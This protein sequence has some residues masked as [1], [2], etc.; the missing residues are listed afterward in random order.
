MICIFD[1]ML[2]E[3]EMF[4]VMVLRVVNVSQI[5]VVVVVCL[6]VFVECDG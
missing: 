1:V 2:V 6:V 3:I 4:V 5:N